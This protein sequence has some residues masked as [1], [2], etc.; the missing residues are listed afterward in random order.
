MLKFQHSKIVS[1]AFLSQLKIIL[2]G[3]AGISQWCILHIPP[4]STEFVY[5]PYF[6]KMYIISPVICVQFRP[7]FVLNLRFLASLFW[8]WCIYSSCIIHVLNAPASWSLERLQLTPWRGAIQILA[9]NE[10]FTQK[11]GQRFEGDSEL[12]VLSVI[13]MAF[14]FSWRS[15][16]CKTN[17]S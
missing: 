5:S 14:F 7:T 16:Q 9:M 3:C 13:L 17:N 11:W 10:W 8:P 12:N 4:I 15:F 2:L 1:L 6:R